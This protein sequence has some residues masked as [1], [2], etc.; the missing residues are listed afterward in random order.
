[1]STR[2]ERWEIQKDWS[3]E[4]VVEFTCQNS[5]AHSSVLKDHAKLSTQL[6][7][8][9]LL[10]ADCELVAKHCGVSEIGQLEDVHASHRRR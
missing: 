5:F 8:M 7:A 9:T 6:K 3:L 1:M 10:N 2:A 4:A